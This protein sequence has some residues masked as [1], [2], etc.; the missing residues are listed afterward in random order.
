MTRSNDFTWAPARPKR[1]DKGEQGKMSCT[2]VYKANL[3]SQLSIFDR[4]SF[5]R[6]HPRPNELTW[7]PSNNPP[8][9]FYMGACTTETKP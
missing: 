7:T 8:E 2:N 4:G 5:T 6:A 1:R 9:Q 3:L